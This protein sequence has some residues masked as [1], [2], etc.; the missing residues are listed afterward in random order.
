MASTSTVARPMG[1]LPVIRDPLI[2]SLL[3]LTVRA[4]QSKVIGDR[5]ATMLLGYDV[6]GLKRQRE[7]ELRDEAV[8]AA[9]PGAR[10][11]G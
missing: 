5:L 2:R 8:L 7:R 10:P 1:V 9:V 3:A 6:V 4:S 11:D